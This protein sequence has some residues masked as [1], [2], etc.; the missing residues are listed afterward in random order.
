M[1]SRDDVVGRLTLASGHP[2]GPT[3]S[4]LTAEAVAMADELG[5]DQLAVDAR[6][7]LAEARHRGNEEWKGL[8]PFVWLLARL[9]KRP[10]LFDADRLRRLGWAYERAVPAAADNPAVSIAQVRELEA[11]LRKFFRFLGG[12]THAIHSSLLHAAIMLGLEE[13]AA[14]QAAALRSTAHD[15]ADRAAR[16]DRATR[17][18][19]E[20]RDPLREIEWANIH[21]DWET[22]VTAAAPVLDRRVDGDDQPYAVQSEALLPLLALG[23][24]QAAWDAHVYSY[25]RLRFA[26]NVMSYLGKHLEYLALS[27]RAAR[28]LRIMRS[29]VGRANEAQSARALM[30]LLSGAVL[31][32]RESEREGRGAEPLD[33]GVP[34]VAAWCP[35]PG[36]G[37]GTPL[38]VARPLFEEWAC[39]IAARYDAR[40]GNSAVSSRLSKGLAREPFIRADAIVGRHARAGAR[41]G[42]AEQARPAERSPGTERVAPAEEVRPTRRTRRAEQARRAE[43]ARSTGRSGRTGLVAVPEGAGSAEALERRSRL[44][45]PD[46]TIII[47][48]ILDPVAPEGAGSAEALERR[49]RLRKPDDT[50]IIERALDSEEPEESGPAGAPEE[51]RVPEEPRAL[52]EEPSE[53]DPGTRLA[54]EPLPA[55]RPGP[56]EGG[57]GPGDAPERTA[58]VRVL[59]RTGSAEEPDQTGDVEEILRSWGR[60][61]SVDKARPAPA[62]PA[63]LPD[64]IGAEAPGSSAGPEE[65]GPAE[66]PGAAG[67]SHRAQGMAGAVPAP[68][69][70]VR[71]G[72]EQDDDGPRPSAVE[73][74]PLSD[75]PYPGVDLRAPSPVG[76]AGG[77]L[78]RLEIELRRP[79]QTIEHAFLITQAMRLGLVP[80]P[81]QVGPELVRAAR[82]L[83]CTVADREG[84]Y[85]RAIDELAHLRAH[86]TGVAHPLRLIELDLEAL[87]VGSK[88]DA[89][90]DRSTARTRA[91][92]LAHAKELAEQLT[93][94][95]EPLLD[96]PAGHQAEL[97][98]AYRSATA[99]VRVLSDHDDHQGAAEFLELA[100]LIVP[101]VADFIE[102]HD[103]ALDD[104]LTLLEA[105]A[106]LARGDVRGACALADAVLRRY[107][108]CPVVLAEAGRSVLV[109]A[110]M[111]LGETERA[112]TQS[113]ELL[114]IHLSMG[115]EELA[116][117]LFGSLATALGTSGRLLEA[118]EVLETALVAGVPPALAD[119]LR[120][121]LISVMDQLDEAEGVRDNCLIVAESAL[122]RGETERGADYLLRAASASE[123]LGE[124]A[125]ASHMFERAAELVDT[126]DNAGRVRC[127]RHLRRAGRAA[128][129]ESADLMAPARPDEARALMS[130]A[131]D[132]IESV[133]D[134]RKYSRAVELGDW[135]DDMAWILWRIGEHAEALDH[136][137]RSFAC[138]VSAKDRGTAAHPLTLMAL[139]H[140]EMG[141]DGA[142][143]EDIDRVRRLL[144]HQRWE[145]HPA[146][147]RVTSLEE[148]LDKAS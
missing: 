49:S 132:L 22:A 33:T 68:V 141:D 131:W 30:D 8:A 23:H 76:D 81:D 77:L 148:S 114:N 99:M 80:D 47:E 71:S 108:P 53:T 119:E 24:S 20:G 133:P 94:M 75:E 86:L 64:R 125:R 12:S 143:R 65:V 7:A 138:Y 37:A 83:R 41:T 98:D 104:Q 88:D 115:L 82:S 36:I 28:G 109:R 87:Q 106:L 5:D 110:L 43:R 137:K 45:N 48:R 90:H 95:A 44:E 116:G 60:S 18:D 13:E 62:E 127:A 39:H 130:R 91:D 112:V 11:G 124:S 2:W 92:Q 51:P 69:V 72:A 6:L 111:S 70:A 21:E 54:E 85:E 10:D 121:T 55:G 105:G 78:R 73:P 14:A 117:P 56:A 38:N 42:A 96:A 118:A 139:I 1:T 128:V 34:S 126:S 136:C 101:H 79:G 120:R 113:R 59:R 3:R 144:G 103:G 142:A 40:N 97:V 100:R 17:A 61:G 107:D 27:G 52:E 50:I 29:F 129:A 31:V 9:D 4:G 25:R 102:P 122:K 19:G 135:H 16:A 57:R 145:G 134:S 89:L 123:K 32:L 15:G 74:L 26:P 67:G 140:A 84:D 146:L 66:G 35:G 46:D 63:N 147:A 58:E 93:A